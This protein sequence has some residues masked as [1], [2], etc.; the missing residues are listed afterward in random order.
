MFLVPAPS[1]FILVRLSTSVSVAHLSW[2]TLG[3][4]FNLSKS[5][6]K[7]EMCPYFVTGSVSVSSLCF[8]PSQLFC[9]FIFNNRFTFVF[10]L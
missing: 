3:A 6:D 4:G 8:T 7:I 1:R 2:V 5:V 10:Y 9:V